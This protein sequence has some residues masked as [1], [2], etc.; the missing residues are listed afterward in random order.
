MPPSQPEDECRL[1]PPPE[2]VRDIGR[3]HGCLY[4]TPV[5]VFSGFWKI[6]VAELCKDM[7]TVTCKFGTLCLEAMPFGL[8]NNE[9]SSYISKN[10][11]QSMERIPMSKIV[12]GSYPNI[13]K[14]PH[15]SCHR[16]E[17]YVK[18]KLRSRSLFEA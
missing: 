11:N 1:F 18:I 6:P 13:L 5:P 9:C 16:S 15:K 2:R 3:L 17:N 8:M 4:F 12:H 14:R 7:T 10:D